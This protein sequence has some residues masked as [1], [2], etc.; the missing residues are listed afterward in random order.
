MSEQNNIQLI[1]QSILAY[2]NENEVVEFKK[3]QDQK[4]TSKN[5]TGEYDKIR[6][7]QTLGF[8]RNLD[9]I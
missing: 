4:H 5:E 3:A 8:R 2:G 9:E 1:L 6:K 7:K